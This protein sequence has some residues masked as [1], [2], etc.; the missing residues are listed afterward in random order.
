MSGPRWGACLDG[1]GLVLRLPTGEE[2]GA[3][4]PLPA[5]RG[6]LARYRSRL[7][8]ALPP[9]TGGFAGYISY[10]ARHLFER[11]PRRAVDDLGLPWL[12]WNLWSR[13]IAIDHLQ[14][15]TWVIANAWPEDD[16]EGAYDAAA[17]SVDGLV[18]RIRSSRQ[19]DSALHDEMDVP[20]PSSLQPQMTQAAFESM[21][22]R[23]Q[24]AIRD[25]DIYQANLSQRF[26][27]PWRADPWPL[28]AALR[29]INP[30]PFAAFARLGAVAV[31]SGSP[32]RLMRGDG[33]TV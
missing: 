33:D 26:S 14:R 32:E 5:L 21:V 2:Q 19:T 11:L 3:G 4:D 23:A 13:I 17:A 27:G 1:R 25:G 15:C 8:P 12:Q 24:A 31:V 6:L 30:S 9:F 22:R 20:T 7:D 18:A 10:E 29:R 16:P 28:Y